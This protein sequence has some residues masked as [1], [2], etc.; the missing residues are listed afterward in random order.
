V[1]RADAGFPGNA[2]TGFLSPLL[3]PRIGMLAKVVGLPGLTVTRPKCTV[4]LKCRSIT[5]F[6]RSEGP[7]EV[8]PV[9]RSRSASSKPLLIAST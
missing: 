7:I 3:A 9:V 6:N 8:P 1:T 2:N 4:P 5:G